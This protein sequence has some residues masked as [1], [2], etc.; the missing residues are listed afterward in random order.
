MAIRSFLAFK[1][2][3]DIRSMVDKISQDLRESRMDVKWVEL[4]KIHLTILFLGDLEESDIHRMESTI[5]KLC[6]QYSHFNLSLDGIG[7]FP[8][9]K[10]PRVLW[11]GI[12]GSLDR[13]CVFR[14]DLQD[15]LEPFRIKR[16]GR[17][18]KPHLTLG[19]FRNP[20]GNNEGLREITMKYRIISSPI[21]PVNEL[22]LFKSE[23]KPSG[24][25]Y[26]RLNSWALT[27]E[28]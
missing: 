25:I 3:P 23:L 16:E 6:R 27:G 7:L 13:M 8:N 14:D 26:T 5:E 11:L 28:K 17:A 2:P 10:K 19:R 20:A 1:L 15:H 21:C 9:N 24:A 4:E 22:F 12:G 18:F